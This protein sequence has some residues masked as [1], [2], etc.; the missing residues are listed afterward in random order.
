MGYFK[1]TITHADGVK[2]VIEPYDTLSVCNLFKT[3]PSSTI[4]VE[5]LPADRYVWIVH[6]DGET[7]HVCAT[8][9]VANSNAGDTDTGIYPM[10]LER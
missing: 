10:P 3:H 4:T 7:T 9:A 5:P 1:V 2:Q 8:E 6:R